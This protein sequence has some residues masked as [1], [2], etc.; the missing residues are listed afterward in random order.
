MNLL[1]WSANL[2]DLKENHRKGLLT[3][4]D[5]Q[6]QKNRIYHSLI[7]IIDRHAEKHLANTPS[8]SSPKKS[9]LPYF[10]ALIA[11]GLVA[12]FIISMMTR[13]PNRIVSPENRNKPVDTVQEEPPATKR[14]RNI[15]TTFKESSVRKR[16]LRA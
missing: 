16:H 3:P 6:T 10:V 9:K 13:K 7:E 4:I 12:V 8:V 15:Q 11:I 5:F 14:K 1:Y 2:F